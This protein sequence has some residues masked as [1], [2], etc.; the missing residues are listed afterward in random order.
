MSPS[1][2][3]EYLVN[4]WREAKASWTMWVAAFWVV[5]GV[6]ET[7]MHLLQPL[8]GGKW[9][10]VASIVVSATLALARMRSLHQSA[11]SK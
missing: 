1:S 3:E 6:V 2:L 9:F 11:K 5:L 4:L 7:Q 10:G 8:I